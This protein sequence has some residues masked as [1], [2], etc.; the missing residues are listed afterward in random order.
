MELTTGM[1]GITAICFFLAEMI[2]RIPKFNS[3][4]I[5]IICGGLGLALSL[6]GYYCTSNFPANNVLEA[7]GVGIASGF[8]AT[9]IHQAGKQII[10]GNNK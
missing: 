7:I 5:P 4:W 8:A 10:G 2:K 9:G 1:T 3:K 6:V